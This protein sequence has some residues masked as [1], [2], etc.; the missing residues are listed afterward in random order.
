[1]AETQIQTLRSIDETINLLLDRFEE[2]L[3]PELL[4]QAQLEF[5]EALMA[6]GEKL[7]AI[8]ARLFYNGLRASQKRAAAAEYEA[9]ARAL[10]AEADAQD[11]QAKRLSDYVLDVM[12]E[13]PKPKR[14]VRTMEGETSTFKARAVADSVEIDD[15]GE[16]PDELKTVTVTYPFPQW[17]Q[18]LAGIAH[19]PALD[20]VKYQLFVVG[21]APKAEIKAALENRVPCPACEDCCGYIVQGEPGNLQEVPCPRCHGSGAV[22]AT[23][24]G[25]RLVSG[26]LRLEVS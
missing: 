24:P 25:A 7:D 18:L 12:K 2:E 8:A 22:P 6:R 17:R 3:P 23:V 11:R 9:K 5:R 1:M 21:A 19:L 26:K 20:W 13:M 16:L 14:G 15:L 10:H 4:V